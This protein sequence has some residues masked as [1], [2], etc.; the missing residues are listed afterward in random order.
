MAELKKYG[1]P[2]EVKTDINARILLPSAIE[3]QAQEM[4]APTFP[5]TVIEVFVNLPKLAMK[6]ASALRDDGSVSSN[7]SSTVNLHNPPPNPNQLYS[8]DLHE[9]IVSIIV[10][11]F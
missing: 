3:S 1:C 6:P 2:G 7:T 8:V 10:S 4:P 5:L 11:M 9:V